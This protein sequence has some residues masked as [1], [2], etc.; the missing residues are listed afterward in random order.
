[1]IRECP[2]EIVS[3]G[4]PV[5]EGATYGARHPDIALVYV[6]MRTK[7]CQ[8]IGFGETGSG[9]P[10]ILIEAL[11]NSLY[12]H[13]SETGYTEIAFPDLAGYRPMMTDHGRYS[14]PVVF[15]RTVDEEEAA[16]DSNDT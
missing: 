5:V 7:R 6:N 1:M 10:T 16:S 4:S 3:Q 14:V 8:G 11:E 12:C 13:D 2:F 15:V 9:V